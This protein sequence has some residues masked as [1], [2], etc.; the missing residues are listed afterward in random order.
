MG[1]LFETPYGSAR[2]VLLV[3]ADD[4]IILAPTVEQF[5]EII[6]D[7]TLAFMALD[8]RWKLSKLEVLANE[9]ARELQGVLD[10]SLDI[11]FNVECQGSV[12][13]LRSSKQ[14]DI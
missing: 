13:H 14:I 8:L 1:I 9:Q 6:C 2:I 11:D 5:Y 7:L 3:W 4:L 10:T 12:Q